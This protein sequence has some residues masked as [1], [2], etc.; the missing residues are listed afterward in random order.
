VNSPNYLKLEEETHRPPE[1]YTKDFLSPIDMAA[2]S[3]ELNMPKSSYKSIQDKFRQPASLA[4]KNTAE[5]CFHPP[6]LLLDLTEETGDVVCSLCGA[7]VMERG[8]SS[9]YLEKPGRVD[10]SNASEVVYTNSFPHLHILGICYSYTEKACEMIRDVFN[11]LKIDGSTL[12]YQACHAFQETAKD[13]NIP[14]DK[15]LT[16]KKFRPHMAFTFFTT[17]TEHKIFR[18]PEE[19][20]LLFDVTYK[21]MLKSENL[22]QSLRTWRYFRQPS[23]YCRPS[24]LIFIIC[25]D[26][27]LSYS[28]S[29]AAANVVRDIESLCYGTSPERIIYQVISHILHLLDPNHPD[30]PMMAELD[31]LRNEILR[32]KVN[33]RDQPRSCFIPESIIIKHMVSR[34]L[35]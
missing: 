16:Q 1:Y 4:K 22:N 6:H 2:L 29:A 27:N 35:I 20:A 32:V 24:Q 19:I 31:H 5:E 33:S 9:H 7:V 12:V 11:A 8:I 23:I 13:L 17:L 18:Q 21:Q 10:R 34:H 3:R 15:F 25:A 26:F 14:W 30:K 28:V